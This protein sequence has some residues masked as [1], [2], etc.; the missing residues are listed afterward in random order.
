[1]FSV[2]N[3][4]WATYKRVLGLL[5]MINWTSLVHIP[6]I[7]KPK[8]QNRFLLNIQMY[9]PFFPLLLLIHLP[10]LNGVTS[11]GTDDEDVEFL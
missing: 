1:M 11:G 7:L 9:N 8:I 6:S 10:F 2:L 3:W 5:A 4:R